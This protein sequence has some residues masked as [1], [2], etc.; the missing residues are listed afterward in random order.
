MR[1]V[2]AQ[3]HRHLKLMIKNCYYYVVM[4]NLFKNSLNISASAFHSF[5]PQGGIVDITFISHYYN[6][7]F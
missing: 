7:Y 3:W 4:I 6:Y 5:P 2:L 1:W